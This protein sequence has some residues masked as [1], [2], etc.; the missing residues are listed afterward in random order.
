MKNIIKNAD[1]IA[2]KLRLTLIRA[3]NHRLEVTKEKR[4]KKNK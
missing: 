4:Q 3:T 2:Y 1:L